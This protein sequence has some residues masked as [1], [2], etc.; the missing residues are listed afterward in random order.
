V[1]EGQE[2]C[3]GVGGCDGGREGGGEGGEKVGGSKS[4]CGNLSTGEK[5]GSRSDGGNSCI[6]T[7][8][9]CGG[10]PWQSDAEK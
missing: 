9:R 6:T 3:A 10:L 5:W 7:V 8:A 1:T 4:D 2:D